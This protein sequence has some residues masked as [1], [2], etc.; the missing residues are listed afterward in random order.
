MVLHPPG[1]ARRL[2]A[3]RV[4][5]LRD[6][7]AEVAAELGRQTDWMVTDTAVP[8]RAVLLVTKERALPARPAGPRRG[9]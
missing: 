7:F 5:E 8:K 6:R 2:A 4:D 3:L 1:R 9:R